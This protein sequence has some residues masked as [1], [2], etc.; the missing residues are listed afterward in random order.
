VKEKLR[1]VGCPALGGSKASLVV[2][3]NDPTFC[4]WTACCGLRV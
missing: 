3:E 4:D 1:A 2:P